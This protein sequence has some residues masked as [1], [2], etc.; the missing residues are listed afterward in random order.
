MAE[1][2]QQETKSSGV[3]FSRGIASA[4]QEIISTG[5]G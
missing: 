3:S 4:V 1:E 2:N 5:G